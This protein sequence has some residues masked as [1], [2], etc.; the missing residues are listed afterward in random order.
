MFGSGYR[1]SDI[2]VLQLLLSY[3][4]PITVSVLKGKNRSSY[5][6]QFFE[7]Y[8][9]IGIE[10]LIAVFSMDVRHSFRHP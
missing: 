2:L 10:F 7:L 4:E 8:S 1:A 3:Q 9:P 5:F 6:E